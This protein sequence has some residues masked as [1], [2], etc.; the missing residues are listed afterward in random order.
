MAAAATSA[1]NGS[2]NARDAIADRADSVSVGHAGSER[3]IARSLAAVEERRA[4]LPPMLV[5]DCGAS[6]P[7]PF[8]PARA[9]PVGRPDKS[10][11]SQPLH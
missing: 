4:A 8:T 7:L 9:A 2:R 6:I 11:R 10:P 3:Q 5:A 1:A